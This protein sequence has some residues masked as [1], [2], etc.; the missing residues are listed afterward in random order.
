MSVNRG[1][2]KMWY[3]LKW[4]ITHKKAEILPL[5][6]TWMDLEI[7]ILNELRITKTMISFTCGI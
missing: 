2:K 5:A 3:I 1:I 7:I 4:N 6:A